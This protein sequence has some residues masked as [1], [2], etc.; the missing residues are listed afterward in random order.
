MYVYGKS[1]PKTMAFS[2]MFDTVSNSYIATTDFLNIF[3]AATLAVVLLKLFM[4]RG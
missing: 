2:G 4:A 1:T 3:A